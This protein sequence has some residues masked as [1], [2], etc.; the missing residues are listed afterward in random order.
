[1]AVAG[2]ILRNRALDAILTAAKP[3]DEE[4]NPVDLRLTVDE[5]VTV[6]A[7][8][9]AEPVEEVVEGQVVSTAEEEE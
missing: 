6:E 1:L 9:V 8:I 3:V 4:G 5:D 2:D 7:E